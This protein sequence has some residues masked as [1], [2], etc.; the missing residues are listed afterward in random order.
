MARGVSKRRGKSLVVIPLPHHSW[1]ARIEGVQGEPRP[2]CLGAQRISLSRSLKVRV[3]CISA[4]YHPLMAY[5]FVHI[6]VYSRRGSKG[7]SVDYVLDEADRRPGAHPHV[8]QPRPPTVIHGATI[9]QVRAMHHDRAGKARQ[10]LANGKT[11]AIRQ[12]QNTLL[13]VVLSHPALTAELQ[14][15]GKAADVG[16]WQER[17]V[18]WLQAQFG[19]RLV[20]VIRH[21]DESHPHLHAYVLP[22]DPAMKATAMHPGYAAKAAAMGDR[23][24]KEANKEG[25]RAYRDAMR[26]WQDQY[27]AEVGLPCG[28][29]RIGPGRRRLD[30]K[31]WR[32][33]KQAA[34][35]VLESKKVA[36]AAI[37]AAEGLKARGERYIQDT[38]RRASAELAAASQAHSEAE[39][40]LALAGKIG[41][42][43]GQAFTSV[44]DVVTRKAVEVEASIRA[45]I[46]RAEAEAAQK[47]QRAQEATKAARE[48]YKREQAVSQALRASAAQLAPERDAAYE[49]LA[50]L[51]PASP[52]SMKPRKH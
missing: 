9:E 38:R 26:S 12:D 50:T 33:E 42:M 45:R 49:Q 7:R 51:S 35:A 4:D 10:S 2:T 37:A 32:A 19:D 28:L 16:L 46:E 30:R 39:A 5:Q 44:R 8:L 43:I 23:T 40:K 25:D 48:A 47:V 18:A 17:N 34:E 31:A 22:D 15:P 27:W 20:S 3:S 1:P 14:D 24:G 21:D 36:E 11:R 6:E 13:T 52:E 41:T 29:T